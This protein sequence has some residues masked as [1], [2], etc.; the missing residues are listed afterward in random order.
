MVHRP[1]AYFK[2]RTGITFDPVKQEVLP[3]LSL[4]ELRHLRRIYSSLLT[5]GYLAI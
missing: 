2:A 5:P 1:H 4:F 3:K